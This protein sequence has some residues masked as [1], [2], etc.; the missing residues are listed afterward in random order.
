MADRLRVTELDFDTIKT[1]LKTFLKQQAEFTDY[2]FDG[3]G[4]SVLI[5]LLAYNTHY[6]AYYVNMVANEAFLD[7]ALLR[8]STVSHAKTLGYMPHSVRAPVAYVN[9]TI[10]TGSSTKSTLVLP[11]GFSFLS[12]QIDSKSYNF[13]VLDNGISDLNI[14]KTGTQFLFENVAIYEGQLI[15]YNFGYNRATNPKQVFTLPDTNIDTSTLKVSVQPAV[16]NTASSVYSKVTDVLDV[17]STAEVFFLQ[18][19]KNGKYQIYFGNGVVGKAL[20]DGATV[21]ATYLITNG[22]AANKANNFVATS[23]VTDSLGNVLSNFTINPLSS[24]AGGAERESVDDIKFSATAQFSAQNRLVSYK[25]YESYILNNYP[26]LESVSVWGGENNIPKTY[27]KVYVSLKPYDGFYVSESEKIRIIEEIIKPK[28]VVTVQTEILD[29]DYLYLIVE[30]KVQYDSKKLTGGVAVL[31]NSIRNSVI[32]YKNTN[33]N[34][35]GAKFILSKLQ[36]EVDGTDMNVIVGSETIVRLEKRFKPILGSSKNYSI[37]YNVPLHRGT[38]TNKL[39]TSEFSVFDTQGVLRNVV[40]DEVP[41]S[42]SGI[43]NISI[44]NP[45]TGYTTAPTVTITGDGIGATA[46][47]VIVNGSVQSINVINRGIDYTRAIITITGGNGYGAAAT[48]T[49]DARTGVIRTAYYDTNTQR[50]IVNE[51]AGLID[52]DAGVITINDINIQAVSTTDGFIRMSIESEKGIIESIRN[53][54]I[55]IDETDPTSIVNTLEA[56]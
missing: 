46:E 25:D 22:T 21:S 17:T 40:F 53:T 52:Y 44:V 35:F 29:P 42:F 28:A 38:I 4:L 20:P 39:L 43:A 47:A 49:I 6:N 3:S 8:D 14:S 36:D 12:N 1:N 5:D 24:A 54:I 27:G 11:E 23:T 48:G 18:E 45:G 13:V 9:I 16:S 41:Q 26:T 51:N 33:L 30:S 55:T 19:S 10:N 32:N 15:T 2:D 7:T 37:Y 31:Q 50:Q 56:D 34:K